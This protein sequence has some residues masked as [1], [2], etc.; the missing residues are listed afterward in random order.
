MPGDQGKADRKAGRP[1]ADQHERRLGGDVRTLPSCKS[2]PAGGRKIALA[3][4][5][6]TASGTSAASTRRCMDFFKKDFTF[7]S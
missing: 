6:R 4:W 7:S 3:S 1:L 2:P 5:I